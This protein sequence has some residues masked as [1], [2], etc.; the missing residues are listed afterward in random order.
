VELKITSFVLEALSRLLA[1]RIT[2]SWS[3]SSPPS[4][5]AILTLSLLFSFSIC[6]ENKN[7]MTPNLYKNQLEH[8]PNHLVNP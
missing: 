6:S 8:H 2:L 5:S 4:F 7:Q 3:L 1:T